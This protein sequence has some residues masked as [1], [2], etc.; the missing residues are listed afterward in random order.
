MSLQIL[1][2]RFKELRDE[3]GLSLR[4]VANA[5]TN[6]KGKKLN[7]RTP[8]NVENQLAIRLET[9]KTIVT[10]A[11][12]LREGSDQYKELMALWMQASGMNTATPAS[13]DKG[14]DVSKIKTTKKTQRFLTKLAPVIQRIPV[15]D[16]KDILAALS[17]PMII[18]ALKAIVEAAES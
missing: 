15:E 4:D 3:K 2:E 12:G 16:E 1:A 11:F 18:K 5:T 13:I 10:Q 14:V 6:K 9:L 7:V 17:N 8:W